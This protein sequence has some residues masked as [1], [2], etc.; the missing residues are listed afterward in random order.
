MTLLGGIAEKHS[1]RPPFDA[2][3]RLLEAIAVAELG[4]WGVSDLDSVPVNFVSSSDTTGGNSGSP[5]LN[6]KGELVGLLFDGT[7]E[8]MLAD[9]H[10]IPE[11]TRSIHVDMRYVL[12][13]MD[14][15]DRAHHLLRELGFE[16][17]SVGP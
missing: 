13:L 1:G 17:A 7:W 14:Y 4:P 16:P 15:V 3:Q 5:T 6:G 12:W 8:G 10:Y 2:P 11:I 9:W